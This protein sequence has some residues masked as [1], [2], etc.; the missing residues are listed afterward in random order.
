MA[1]SNDPYDFYQGPVAE[2]ASDYDPVL[3]KMVSNFDATKDKIHLGKIKT[4]EKF[5]DLKITQ[6]SIA[7][8]YGSPSEFTL[9]DLGNGTF[10]KLNGF[11]NLTA[12]NFAF[13]KAPTA[14]LSS[15]NTQTIVKHNVNYNG[16]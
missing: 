7:Q 13:N 2:I 4:L 6:H 11:Y 12:D 5:E 3:M 8:S 16:L 9:I 14:N 1:E 10:V 15:A